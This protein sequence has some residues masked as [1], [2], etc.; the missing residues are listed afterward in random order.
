MARRNFGI[1]RTPA[2]RDDFAA[3]SHVKVRPASGARYVDLEDLVD[4]PDVQTLAK[5][6]A[7]LKLP[8]ENVETAG[9]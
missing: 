1:P 6:V 4:S 5:Q 2:P 3:L 8:S 9:S 7:D